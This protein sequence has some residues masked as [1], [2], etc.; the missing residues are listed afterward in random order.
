MI[1]SLFCAKFSANLSPPGGVYYFL[2]ADQNVIIHVVLD[3]ASFDDACANGAAAAAK[4]RPRVDVSL[5]DVIFGAAPPDLFIRAKR[6]VR[7]GQLPVERLVPFACKQRLQGCQIVKSGPYLAP[8][9]IGAAGACFFGAGVG[10][11][12]PA[13]AKRAFPPDLSV[14]AGGCVAGVKIAVFLIIPLGCNFREKRHEIGLARD[15]PVARAIGAARAAPRHTVDRRLPAVPAF[16]T[17]PHLFLVMHRHILGA[18]PPVFF[19]IPQ[20]KHTRAL[21][22]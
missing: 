14:R 3:L 12:L 5:P 4:S 8:R 9:A 2:V 20:I 17:P 22:R 7:G 15:C 6:D 19:M 16:A 21:L 18:Q 1:Q 13:V 10:R 11:G